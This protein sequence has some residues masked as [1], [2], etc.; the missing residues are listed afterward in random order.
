[1]KMIYFI[2]IGLLFCGLVA[3]GF[4]LAPKLV[5]TFSNNP[6]DNLYGERDYGM[7]GLGNLQVVEGEARW[8]Q[9]KATGE[10]ADLIFWTSST[11]KKAELGWIPKS[12]SCS[13]WVDKYLYDVNG[14]TILDDKPKSITL[15]CESAKCGGANCYHISLTQAQAINIDTHVRLGNNSQV[16]EYQNESRL[17]Y[18]LDFADVNITLYKN[19]SG[20]WNNT[21]KDIWVY[22]NE[23]SDKFGANDSSNEG[24]EVYKYKVESS[25]EIFSSEFTPF[26][27]NP[28]NSSELHEFNFTDVCSEN[29][30][31][32][33]FTYYKEGNYILEV[34]FTSDS[35]ID[36]K[37]SIKN[38]KLKGYNYDKY[39][40][41]VNVKKEN[42]KPKFYSQKW[43][44]E[45]YLN[46]TRKTDSNVSKEKWKD[47]KVEY[48]DTSGL[49]DKYYS[50]DDNNFEYEVIFSEQP[51]D[52]YVEFDLDFSEGLKFN[53]QPPLNIETGNASCNATDC[54]GSHRP[55][56]VVGSY[57]VYWNKRN[58]KYETGKFAH[59]YRPKLIDADNNEIWAEINITENIMKII[60][61][62]TWL[63]NAVYPVIIDP[64]V[65][66]TSIGGSTKSETAQ[67]SWMSDEGWNPESDGSAINMSLYVT[68]YGAYNQVNF[69][70]GIYS[71]ADSRLVRTEESVIYTNNGNMWRHI[72]LL[73]PYD[74]YSATAYRLDWSK[75]YGGFTWHYDSAGTYDVDVDIAETTPPATFTRDSERRANCHPSIYFTYDEG[76]GD[77]TN[78]NVTINNPLNQ[79]YTTN[80]INFNVT[81]V[82]ETELDTCL[83]SFNGANFFNMTN[84]TTSP[85]YYNATNIT[86]T[87]GSLR[88]T[89]YCNDTT[90][91]LNNSEYVDFYIDSIIPSV[92]NL[93][94]PADPI[95]Y[96]FGQALQFNATVT[97]TNL[98][99]VLFE[100]NG[101]NYTSVLLSGNI[102][103]YTMTGLSALNYSYTWCANDSLNNLNCSEVGSYNI[104]TAI[105]QG[106]ITGTSPITYGTTGDVEGTETNNGDEDVTYGLFK[107]NLTVSNPDVT[108][109]SAGTHVY[110]Y[111]ATSGSNYTTNESIGRFTL[112]VNQNVSLINLTLDA[113]EGNVSISTGSSIDINCSTITGDAGG[114]LVTY[115]E[116]ILIN[117]GT[118]P[119]NNLTTFDTEGVYNIT[120]IYEE[121]TNFTRTSQEWY[122]NATTTDITN[123]NITI[124]NP[125]NQT[126]YSQTTMLFNITALDNIEIDTC[127]YSLNNGVDNYTMTNASTSPNDYNHTNSTIGEGRYLANFYCN[128]T[129]GNWN[130]T[131]NTNFTIDTT[132]PYF[133]ELPVNQ[134]QTHLESTNYDMN[135]TDEWIDVDCF[136]VN[137][138]SIFNISCGGVL[139]NITALTVKNYTINIT[140]ND[141]LNHLNSTILGINVTNG[142]A[143]DITFPL[144]TTNNPINQTN[145]SQTTMLFN[146]TATDD[147]QIAG[148]WYTLNNGVDNYTMTN[149]STSPNDYNHTNS[150]IGEGRYLTN[151]YCND[152]TNNV[153]NSENVNFTIDLTPPYFDELPTN[154]SH[155]DNQSTR[156]DMNATDSFT[157]LDCFAVNETSTFNITCGGLL[158]N[159]TALTVKNYTLNITINDS[160]NNLNSTIIGI[161]V[162]SSVV[163]DSI[164]P[165]F[166]ELPTNQ[167]IYNNQSLSYDMNASDETLFDCF[168]VN[169]TTNFAVTCGG[170]L[171][172]ITALTVKNYTLNITIND[173][174]N[175]LNSTI[176]G[177]NVKNASSDDN[178]PPIITNPRNLTSI[179]NTTFSQEMSA[180]DVSGIG[181]Y[182]LNDTTYFNISQTGVITNATLLD[183]VTLYN[184]NYSVNDTQGNMISMI[185]WINITE[186]PTIKTISECNATYTV[187]QSASSNKRP[188]GRM[189]FWMD[190]R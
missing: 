87:Q 30:S 117:N 184:L 167:S 59:I 158:V 26:V 163:V 10:E 72:D 91:N 86:M 174:L 102:Y 57:A 173:N 23:D 42:D 172:N 137:E 124:N 150:T 161:N 74:V 32:C 34:I 114:F 98:D 63:N 111:N 67:N 4:F 189:C 21:I 62:E 12:G 25:G 88:V 64:K 46:I 112:T 162:T 125:L 146:A 177:I 138:T 50:I 15:K 149:A 105:P 99:T 65:G 100:F 58:N 145:Y 153:N 94:E 77:S 166:D 187:L 48:E 165:Y 83:Y 159:T 73:S 170:L 180:T 97:D 47:N 178:A 36:P 132:P 80:T 101:T 123:P 157:D 120:C 16:V 115:N 134:S 122:V 139:N 106:S 14:N 19:I 96:S 156:Y 171:T 20:N 107:N 54:E 41:K 8:Q 160:A 1:M 110:N 175:N 116:T 93:Q 31:S 147:T 143:P 7:V 186:Q 148:C 90:N 169:D 133:N 113:T 140:I 82:D 17:N 35:D 44:D 28:N 76:G 81:S 190:F 27:E 183:N 68:D 152:T 119:T 155:Y 79:T 128:D 18:Q 85:T 92:T 5:E 2:L 164:P 95:T 52:N 188:Y 154:Q 176:L 38:A 40:A 75:S 13:G 29:Y 136:A 103:N 104:S 37:I 11:D 108:I 6:T 9:I 22:S 127:L 121:T 60:M 130:L 70:M 56:D 118:S 66:Y 126:N 181:T 129:K 84:A 179:G 3:G 71:T 89:Y 53:Y 55:I 69:S 24:L 135:A 144:V 142:T 185:F 182:A 109:L 78:P 168:A 131:E 39:N 33:E 141:S 49:I 61:N 151:F 45:A 51:I 43:N